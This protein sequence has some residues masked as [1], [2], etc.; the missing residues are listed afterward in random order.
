[1]PCHQCARRCYLIKGWVVTIGVWGALAAL[2]AA[3]QPET[4]ILLG[5]CL[6]WRVSRGMIAVCEELATVAVVVASQFAIMVRPS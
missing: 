6:V 3:S 5:W 2:S 1:M 4:V